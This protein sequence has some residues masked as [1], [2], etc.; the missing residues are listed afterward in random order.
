MSDEIVI[1]LTVDSSQAN[2]EI[3]N[4]K[5]KIDATVEDWQIKRSDIMK[6]LSIMGQSLMIV[7]RFARMT[8]NRILGAIV[9][10][11]Q[12]LIMTVIQTISTLIAVQTAEEASG[13]LL[14][15]AA[16]LSGF[17]LGLQIGTLPSLI[18][19]QGQIITKQKVLEG[20]LSEFEALGFRTPPGG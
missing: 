12:T 16:I 3:A 15:I 2:A 14:P 10:I 11:F 5:D 4:V 13:V 19:A 20:R 6:G 8:G 1:G 7:S 17:I 9:S 18:Q